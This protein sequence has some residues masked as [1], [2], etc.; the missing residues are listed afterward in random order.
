MTGVNDFL[1]FANASG[2]N[3]ETQADY[4]VD[5]ILGPGFTSGI[6]PSI[7][8]N[9]V[10]RQATVIANLIGNFIAQ[11]DLNANDNGDPTTLLANFIA[12]L[13]TITGPNVAPVNQKIVGASIGPGYNDTIN[14][15][16]TTFVPGY[17]TA[18]GILNMFTIAGGDILLKLSNNVTSDVKSDGCEGSQTQISI[19]PVTSPGETI[20]SLQVQGT[21]SGWT[22]VSGSFEVYASFTPVNS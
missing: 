10:W 17:I 14:V 7:K 18:I 21:G 22:A 5:G 8:A 12:A 13:Q 15:N 2:A 6:A 11:A 16:L 9:K 4:A 20:I 1:A 19:I 3:V